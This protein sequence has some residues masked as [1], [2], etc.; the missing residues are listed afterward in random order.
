MRE[1]T[2]LLPIFQASRIGQF[3]LVIFVGEGARE[4]FRE[5]DQE[6]QPFPICRVNPN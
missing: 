6:L 1:A 2:I 3:S 5:A 4:S